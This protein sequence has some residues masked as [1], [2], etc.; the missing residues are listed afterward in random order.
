M[1][2][3][4][5]LREFLELLNSTSVNYVVVGGYA[6]AYHGSPRFTGDIDCLVELSTENAERLIEVI[7][8]FGFADLDIQRSDFLNPDSVVQ[9]GV[10]PNRIDLLTAIDGVTF[11]EVWR[12]RV[13]G[14]LDGLPV[15]F[16]SKEL[17]LQNKRAAGRAKDL[18]DVVSL[19]KKNPGR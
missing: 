1:R 17:L 19:S 4:K 9:L 14:Q 16:I 12:T 3:Q 10:P 13:T 8:R 5:D 11:D 18:A 2:L 7:N 15:C 6:V